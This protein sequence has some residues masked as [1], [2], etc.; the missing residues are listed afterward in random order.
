MSGNIERIKRL[1]SQLSNVREK[2][3]AVA[4]RTVNGLITVGAGFG[5]GMAINKLGEDGKLLLPGTDVD[6][7]LAGGT[8]LLIAGIA[9][10]GGDKYSEALSAAGAG[11]LA[12]QL[13]INTYQDG[14]PFS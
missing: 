1:T 2:T 13:A 3:E 12:G 9:G 4:G 11:L 14:R 5:L 6:A 7:G 10:L 8:L